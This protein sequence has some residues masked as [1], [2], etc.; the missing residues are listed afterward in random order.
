[1][2]T[3]AELVKLL[4]SSATAAKRRIDPLLVRALVL[5]LEGVTRIVL[6]EGGEG[7]NVSDASIER[8]RRVMMRLATSAL[9]GKGAGVAPLPTLR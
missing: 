2:E 3:H 1:M 4:M 6:E 7:R 8:A 5:A 9:S